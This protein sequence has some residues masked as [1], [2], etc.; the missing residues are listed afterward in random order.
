MAN[1]AVYADLLDA[2]SPLKS[3]GIDPD[4]ARV[5]PQAAMAKLN[6]E[7][8]K[9]WYMAQNDA[10]Q[11]PGTSP[12]GNALPPGLQSRTDAPAEPAAV[13]AT[14]TP[15]GDPKT[16][17]S[18]NTG[19]INLMQQD[20]A[21]ASQD[22]Q[23]EARQPDLS[24]VTAPL[25]QQR[26]SAQRRQVELENPYDPKTGKLLEEYK[27][28]FGQR[29]MRGVEGFARGGVLGAVNPEMTGA[30]AYGAPNKFLAIGQQQAAGRVAGTDQQLKQAADAWKATNDRLKQI[31]T[32]R[33]ALATTG[34]DVTGA[35]E[36]QQKLPIEQQKADADSTNAEARSAGSGPERPGQGLRAAFAGCRL[37][38]AE[39]PEP[40]ALPRQR[41]ATRPEAGHL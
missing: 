27:P 15:S 40:D 11:Q 18:S 3:A 23:N 14:V 26:V 21:R 13:P 2:L 25:E 6:P 22:V 35:A 7:Q 36:A 39:G 4:E 16:L 32:E 30:K 28:T 1:D 9:P 20:Y 24:A 19:V 10:P 8:P 34:K 12:N 41:Q 37:D 5:N 29:L 17:A 33:R 31:A 38:E